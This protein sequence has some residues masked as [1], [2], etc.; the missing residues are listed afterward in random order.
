MTTP[1]AS[2]VGEVLRERTAE[3]AQHDCDDWA[4]WRKR[5]SGWRPGGRGS[6][7]RPGEGWEAFV[8]RLLSEG[9]WEP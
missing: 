6:T 8:G 1:L 4:A 5:E 7:P 2:A 3:V 9:A